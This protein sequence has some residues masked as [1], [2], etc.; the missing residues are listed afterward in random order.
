MDDISLMQV[1]DS[2]KDLSEDPPFE[3]LISLARI[4]HHKVF[5]SLSST[6]LHLDVE[7][8]NP[9][10]FG[11]STVSN[12]SL[13]TVFSP[14][15]KGSFIA[16]LL[17][18]ELT[19]IL[20]VSL[21]GEMCRVTILMHERKLALSLFIVVLLVILVLVFVFFLRLLFRY[22]IEFKVEQWSLL[23]RFKLML[24]LTFRIRSHI[25]KLLSH[26]SFAPADLMLFFWIDIVRLKML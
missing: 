1:I 17:G 26:S 5:K 10:V 7:Y 12:L 18:G 22:R 2:F 8:L 4:V 23:E 16:L 11:A 15:D 6:V 21:G 20:A 13:C 14:H 3:L 24:S 25:L 9:I 19:L